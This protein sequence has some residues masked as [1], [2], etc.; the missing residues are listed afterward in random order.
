MENYSYAELTQFFFLAQSSMDTQFQY[1]ITVTFAA[2]VA[3]FVAGERLTLSLRILVATLYLLASATLALRFLSAVGTAT[4]IA[5]FLR[6]ADAFVIRVRNL[7]LLRPPLFVL[8]TGAA[9]YFLIRP[10]STA[11]Q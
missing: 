3:G 2:V 9:T 8:G 5:Q 10:R 11:V 6:E 4:D 7:S 1:W